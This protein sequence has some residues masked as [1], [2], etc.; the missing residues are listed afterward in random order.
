MKHLMTQPGHD[1]RRKGG[2]LSI[3]LLN[4]DRIQEEKIV[5]EASNDSPGQD[6]RANGG[7]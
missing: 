3:Q 4:Q 6:P 7:D 2:D 1:P 5:A